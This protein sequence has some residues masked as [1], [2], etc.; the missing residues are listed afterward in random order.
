M[1][2]THTERNIL[3][4]SELWHIEA[5][6]RFLDERK[7]IRDEGYLLIPLD[8]EVESVLAKKEIAFQSGKEYR[9]PDAARMI[10]AEEWTSSIFESEPWSFFTYRGVSLGRLYAQ[11][12]QGYI[13]RILYYTDI[14][15]NVIA[16]HQSIQRLI[17]FPAPS[18]RPPVERCLTGAMI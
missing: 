13:S 11:S 1:Q 2:T 4:L 8:A 5:L 7:D 9:T 14:V 3:F 12:L 18:A 10:L 16:R 6:E 17:V 15:S